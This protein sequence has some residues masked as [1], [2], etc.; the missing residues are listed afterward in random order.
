MEELLQTNE[1]LSS[2]IEQNPSITLP[3]KEEEN[4][5][6]IDETLNDL[7]KNPALREDAF[8]SALDVNDRYYQEIVHLDEV[9][10][11]GVMKKLTDTAQ[12]IQTRFTHPDAQKRD[13]A[14]L[15]GKAFI[16]KA[17]SR[18]QE[19]QAPRKA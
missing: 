9:S 18:Y 14:E 16:V 5:E 15:A 8:K 6:P 13:N 10:R 11:E 7:W 4:R 12:F 3:G 17:T 2:F 19:L 1:E